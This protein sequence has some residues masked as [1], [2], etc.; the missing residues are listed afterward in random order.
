MPLFFGK[1]TGA[2][3]PRSLAPWQAIYFAMD[4]VHGWVLGFVPLGA[5][6]GLAQKG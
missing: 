5:M 3:E 6:G 2:D 4:A 1:R